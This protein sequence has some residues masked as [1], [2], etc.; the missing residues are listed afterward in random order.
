MKKSLFLALIACVTLV[1]VGCEPPVTPVDYTIMLSETEL[2]MELGKETKLTAVATP[3]STYALVWESSNPEVATVNASGIVNSVGL[4]T[5]TI[6]VKLNTPA[7]DPAVGT[8]TPATCVVT[9]TNDAVLNSF[10]IGGYALFDLGN[11]I[12]GTDTV[13]EISVGQVTVQLAPSLYYVWDKGIVLSGNSLAGAGFL[14]PVE[15]FTYVITDS[16]NGQYNGYYISGYDIV[17]DTIAADDVIPYTGKA[18]ELLDVNTYGDAWS[19]ILA[20][21]TEDDIYAA[22]DLYYAS[23]AGTPF[24]HIDFNT[25]SQS[26]YYGNVSYMYLQEDRETAELYYALK[27][28]WYDHV[29]LVVG[30]V[31]SL[32]QRLMKKVSR[33]SPV[34]LSHTIC[35]LSTKSIMYCLLQRMR[36]QQRLRLSNLRSLSASTLSKLSFLRALLVCTRNN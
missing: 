29:T 14:L 17:V 3:T 35:V 5:A 13:I 2:T 32:R 4:G 27:L 7:E 18:G 34:S 19:G 30:S 33:L 28:E 10:E 22:Y 26:Y 23:Q 9:V 16:P 12:A 11:P 8:V 25:G 31:F 24:F 6:T 36:S 15:N 20:A 1:F 21:E